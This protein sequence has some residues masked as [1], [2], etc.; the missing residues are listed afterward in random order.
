[1]YQLHIHKTHTITATQHHPSIPPHP[2]AVAPDVST[3][4]QAKCMLMR[5]RPMVE[6]HSFW[7]EMAFNNG[8]PRGDFAKSSAPLWKTHLIHC[9]ACVLLLSCSLSSFFCDACTG[10]LSPV[11]LCW[12]T[13]E[14]WGC[15]EL[16]F[17]FMT[18]LLNLYVVKLLHVVCLSLLLWLCLC[19]D[20]CP[21]K[22]V[23][24]YYMHFK[25]IISSGSLGPKY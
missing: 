22:H 25:Q 4:R 12:W 15:R 16:W 17:F 11:Y 19:W 2:P 9:C 23:K 3:Q 21:H 7:E 8:G 20:K 13:E 14:F 6:P 1:M 18:P 10:R 24:M 5:A